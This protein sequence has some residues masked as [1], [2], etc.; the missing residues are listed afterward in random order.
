MTD[1]DPWHLGNRM[2]GFAFALRGSDGLR[3]DEA[4]LWW[5][6]DSDLDRRARARRGV[7]ALGVPTLKHHDPNGYTNRQPELSEQAG[8]D[9]ETFH[10][11]HGFLPW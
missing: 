2:V 7:C 1:H 10:R 8:R 3:A 6:G 9:R 4:F 5:W 11:V